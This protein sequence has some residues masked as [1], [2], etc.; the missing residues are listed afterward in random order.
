MR[1]HSAALLVVLFG[2][3]AVQSSPASA[4]DRVVRVV[5]GYLHGCAL[6]AEGAVYCWGMER[7]NG[8]TE[9]TTEAQRVEGLPK[10]V[11]LAAGHVNSCIL[12]AEGAAWCWGVDLQASVTARHAMV[13]GPKRVSGLAPASMIASGHLHSCAIARHDG[14]VWCWGANAAGELG[15]GTLTDSAIP[16]RAGAL[17]QASWISAGVNNSCAIV[18]DGQVH[19]WGTDLESGGQIVKSRVPEPVPLAEPS[20]AIANGRNFFCGLTSTSAVICFGSNILNQLGDAALGK[21]YTI[22]RLPG[23]GGVRELGVGGFFGCALLQ[24]GSVTCWGHF[25]G[26]NEFD[27][28]GTG[29]EPVPEI[30]GGTGLGV[31]M[32]TACVLEA[33]GRVLCWGSN[34]AGQTGNGRTSAVEPVPVEVQ[35]LPHG[36]TAQ[37]QARNASPAAGPH[38]EYADAA[39][40]RALT[41][42][43][44]GSLLP[45]WWTDGAAHGQLGA[46]ATK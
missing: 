26:G 12:D 3:F 4:A 13:G 44:A 15:D 1:S 23:V 22:G 41:A 43:V 20:V 36:E 14:S 45:P 17:R 16:V 19:C 25:P 10:A 31:G 33:D 28:E 27:F 11:A 38:P 21:T 34:F 40:L 8:R 46:R 35:G 37:L 9:S 39:L 6:T 2:A 42:P 32:G 7:V 5:P 18:A 24:A 29:P 30:G